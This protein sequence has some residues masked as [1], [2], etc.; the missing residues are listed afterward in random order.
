MAGSLGFE[1]TLNNSDTLCGLKQSDTVRAGK[2]QKIS[3]AE[4]KFQRTKGDR[5]A[6]TPV[7]I[8]FP[9][10]LC[11]P[12]LSWVIVGRLETPKFLYDL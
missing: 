7:S 10:A 11:Y 4:S 1:Q 9:L 8:L 5:G 3:L 12:G 6:P 2:T